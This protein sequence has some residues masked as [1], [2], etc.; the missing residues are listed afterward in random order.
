MA[1][2]PLYEKYGTNLSF[3]QVRVIQDLAQVALENLLYITTTGNVGI[4]TTS[5]TTK[6]NAQGT[7]AANQGPDVNSAITWPL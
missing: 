5:P 7:P 3:I 2:I 1:A 4:G 6:L